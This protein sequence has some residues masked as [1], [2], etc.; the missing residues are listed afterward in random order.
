[1]KILALEASTMAAGAAV[2]D[3]DKLWGES[4][5]DY[6]LKHSEKLL[7]MIHHLLED[8][9]LTM[10]EIDAVAVGKGPGSFTGLRIAAATAKSL[11]HARNLPLI[12]ISS[13]EVCAAPYAY[14]GGIVC[15]I[16]DA[17]RQQVYTAMF[18]GGQRLSP[19]SAVSIQ[20]LNAK[21]EALED[22][23]L[24]TGDGLYKFTTY[25]RQQLG[26]R[27]V[28]A[29]PGMDMPRAG[30]LARLAV[31]CYQAGNYTDYQH[32]LPNYIRASQAE[33]HFKQHE[34]KD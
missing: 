9:H 21:L 28:I 23:V 24:F 12:P 5:T 30:A 3:E 8:L 10:S 20:E 13:L 7:P 11:V 1:M 31:S 17:Q 6:K 33:A 16:F 22:A 4:F 34:P 18:K 27:A 14:F 2:A 29:R 19:D 26:S 32:Y 25:F 15:P